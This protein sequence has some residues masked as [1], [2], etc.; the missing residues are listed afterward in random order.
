MVPV[1][2]WAGVCYEI[3]GLLDM[4]MLITR[5]YILVW[6]SSCVLQKRASN[7]AC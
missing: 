2:G 5:L 7:A 3:Q 6:R 1:A 4:A